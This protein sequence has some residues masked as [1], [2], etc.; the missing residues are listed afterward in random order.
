MHWT[1]AAPWVTTFLASQSSFQQL[2]CTKLQSAAATNVVYDSLIDWI[3]ADKQSIISDKIKLQ[4]SESGFGYGAF[5][6]EECQAGELLFEIPTSQTIRL[7]D[8]LA[9]PTIGTGLKALVDTA[10]PG[11]NT[12]ALAGFLAQERLK[13]DDSLYAPYL[14]SLPWQRDIE[15][16]EHILYW[17]D[18]E[19]EELLEGT[20][21]YGEALDLR[22]EVG[23]A[24]KVLRTIFT[25]KKSGFVLPW[26]RYEEETK[27]L[28][29]PEETKEAVVGSFVTI[30][31]RAFQ[32]L[33]DDNEK[34]VPLLDMLQHS[35]TPN[36]AHVTVKAT[37][38]VQVRARKE[39]TA[40]TELLNQYR[41]ELEENMPYHRFFTRF[42]FV[43]GIREPIVNLLKDKSPI[44]Y[45]Q[46]AEV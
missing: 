46:K 27:A 22:K 31:T 36:V 29:N 42:G 30:L 40:G 1:L 26:E 45:A 21:S 24:N 12:V 35:D 43:P 6:S 15:N 13:G 20:M 37:G 7:S 39:L 8:A 41:S 10:G 5:V 28:A 38:A 18:D 33:E 17:D 23:V 25:P 11:G 3:K 2:S 9:D 19:V 4:P 34:L 44:F 16:Q 14:N 32:D